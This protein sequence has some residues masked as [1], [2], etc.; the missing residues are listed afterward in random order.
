MGDQIMGSRWHRFRYT[1]NL[2]LYGG[3][4][5]T[6]GP[7]HLALSEEAAGEGIVLLKND[8]LLPLAGGTRAALFG[9]ATFDYVKGGGGSGD[10]TVS[11]VT[12]IYEGLKA[13]PDRIRV[14]ETTIPFY[15]SYVEHEQ[16]K[17]QLPGC[18]AEPALPK[19]LLKKAA[20]DADVAV[21]SLSRFSGEGWDRKMDRSVLS[22]MSDFTLG[23]H[24]AAKIF[25]RGDFYLSE[26]ERALVEQ[27]KKAFR[28]VVVLLNVGGV[29]E[30][31]WFASDPKIQAAMLIGQGGMCGG[32]AA[33]KALL[34]V[35]NPSGRL[36]DTWAAEITDYPS[37]KGFFK[38]GDYVEYEEDI[39]VGY[40][41]FYTMKDASDRVV[42]PFGYGLGYSDFD[43]EAMQARELDG[44]IEAEVTVVNRGPYPG[45]EVVQLYAELPQGKLGKPARTLIA[46]G[47]TKLL[48]PGDS[49]RI[50]L[51]VPVED[52]ASYDD[53][54]KIRKSAWVLEAGVYRFWLG[55]NVRDAWLLDHTMELAK[56]RVTKQLTEKLRPTALR[57]RLT[58]D[59]R[60]EKLPTVPAEKK[61]KDGMPVLKLS[62]WDGYAPGVRA[63]DPPFVYEPDKKI[64]SLSEVA[65][66]KLTLSA[67][68][69]QLND[70][71]LCWMF[72]GQ[73]NIGVA[74]TWGL[75]NNARLGV[76]DVMTADGPAGFRTRPETGVTAT[77]WPV[78]TTLACTWD[79]ELLERVG[80]AAAEEVRENNVGVWLAPALN[81]HR[82]PLCGRNFE[83]FSEDP[84]V[85]GRMAAAVVKG[86]Q[87]QRIAA[88]IK[89]FAF[90]NKESNRRESDSRVSERAA[91]EIY[92]KG[93]EI[94]IRESDPWCVMA[95]YNIVNGEH[96]SS[97]EELLT[98]ILRKEWG[99]QGL[100]MT[101]W[102]ST[103]DPYRDLLA[104]IDLRMPYGVPSRIALALKKGL[105]TRTDLERAARH[106]LELILKLD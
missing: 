47:K 53:L 3:E 36:T 56:D 62:D 58:A 28:R 23:E 60:Y 55:F 10:V 54:G 86:V 77:A 24:Q 78:A 21:I 102:W 13:F 81:I 29:I 12:G 63:E 27:V 14:S 72:S 99:Y 45:R 31:E 79:P 101:D 97:C 4:R 43:L 1:P 94:A 25:E 50:L 39:Y 37:T 6:A 106:I 67:F 44:M 103:G 76:P 104:G 96:T 18:I 9:K 5:V 75:G 38:S 46:F 69:K 2:P 42:Y 34:G 30:S 17:G 20:C 7:E 51:Q 92:L 22:T 40:R 19:D 32:R 91:R 35:I 15:R 105:I 73:P 61:P 88:T 90:N 59:G 98:G 71:D 84:L 11:H 82:S 65:E 80:A 49:Q 85:S 70:D 33:A 8:G 100:V 95:S 66:G 93:F 16:A 48:S 64:R 83:Y 26:A 87:S 52:L 68:M 74:N 41:Y 57:R 89:H